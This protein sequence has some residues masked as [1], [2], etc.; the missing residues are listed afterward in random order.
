MEHD[1]AVETTKTLLGDAAVPALYEPAFTFHGIRT[2]IDVLNRNGWREF[3]LVEVKSSTR[4][5]PEHITDV[6]I[7][8]YAVEG[9]GIPINGAYLMHLN[10]A[11]EYQGGEHDLEQLFT[12][13]DVT[14]RAR[15][16]IEK[17][18]PDDLS[19]MW[20]TLK[21]DAP[22]LIENGPH[23]TRPYRCSFYGHCHQDEPG[24]NGQT[25][26]SPSLQSR[27][28]EIT[29][30][31]SFLD[32]ET[33]SPAIPLYPGTRPYQPIP[34]QWSLHILDS[35]G[36][37]AH[38]SFLNDDAGDPRERFIITLLE[39]IPS[40]GAIVTYSSYE[41]T[42][43]NGLANAFPLYRNRLFALS[44]RIVDLL[45]LI[46]ENYYHP[47]FNGS[48]SLK[49]V[50][51]ALVPNQDYTNMDIQDGAAASMAYTRVS[52]VETPESEKAEIKEALLTYCAQDTE[53]MVGLYEALFDESKSSEPR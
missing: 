1:Q 18:V 52:A 51:P 23:C 50:A 14:D 11:Y 47:D 20:S 28:E 2:R 21:L 33:V 32:F 17:R 44:D 45:K 27:L 39:E 8:V 30:P 40:D 22:P 15:S 48:Y 38:E 31:A 29:F 24:N 46:R 43:L 49:S 36:N 19:R 34:F 4:I 25:F 53:A 37:L 5:K 9:S 13:Q 7:Q 12:L 41:K 42:I 26:I 3:D 16:F 10:N 6:A 35:S